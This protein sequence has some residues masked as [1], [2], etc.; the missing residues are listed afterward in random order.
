MLHY[1]QEC[2]GR[3]SDPEIRELVFHVLGRLELRMNQRALLRFARGARF[4]AV[5]SSADSISLHSLRRVGM[6]TLS[7]RVDA[8]MRERF[9]HITALGEVVLEAIDER[10]REIANREKSVRRAGHSRREARAA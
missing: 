6:M 1:L 9:W 8:P 7:G 3:L 2:S 4:F 10:E 5:T